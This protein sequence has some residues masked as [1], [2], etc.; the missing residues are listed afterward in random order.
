MAYY[1]PGLRWFPYTGGKYFVSSIGH[2]THVL[3]RVF[4]PFSQTEQSFQY[5]R[6]LIL[7][8]GTILTGQY[9][10]VLMMV[11]AIDPEDQIVH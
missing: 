6:P 5:Y 11:T 4:W 7:V 9:R 8:D 2:I 10:G 3:Q 1:N